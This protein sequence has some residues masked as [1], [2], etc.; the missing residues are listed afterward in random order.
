[1][2]C[3]THPAFV[4]RPHVGHYAHSITIVVLWLPFLITVRCTE[5][6]K[7][8]QNIFRLFKR[9]ILSASECAWGTMLDNLIVK[10]LLRKLSSSEVH[11]VI[12]R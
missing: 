1:M 3:L 6:E 10:P 9:L 5:R 4:D 8:V 7:R 11:I 2:R 12:E